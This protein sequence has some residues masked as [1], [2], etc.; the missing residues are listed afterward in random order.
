M[1]K[2]ARFIAANE[3]KIENIPADAEAVS[4][5]INPDNTTTIT[6][7]DG[8]TLDQKWNTLLGIGNYPRI[9]YCVWDN[10]ALTNGCMMNETYKV[11]FGDVTA[12]EAVNM[13]WNTPYIA[14][15]FTNTPIK[16]VKTLA[17]AMDVKY[18]SGFN[19]TTRQL[20]Y[21]SC[22]TIGMW[23]NGKFV[24]VSRDEIVITETPVA[25]PTAETPVAEPT[26]DYT[27]TVTESGTET[28]RIEGKS[29]EFC[30]ARAESI[31]RSYGVYNQ[32][33]FRDGTVYTNGDTVIK[34]L[35][36]NGFSME[37]EWMS[38]TCT[39]EELVLLKRDGAFAVIRQREQKARQEQWAKL[40]KFDLAKALSATV[41]K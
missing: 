10:S 29:L 23:E 32:V 34:I 22:P 25:E 37:D 3:I 8:D 14:Y 27:I 18:Q 41:K 11:M 40:P 31:S 2:L 26:T 6:F 5:R 15:D 39:P 24:K 9:T 30:I 35:S 4:I 1:T 7:Y 20:E 28:I 38:W 21:K 17:E 19:P 13:A 33:M 36:S 12:S 16:V